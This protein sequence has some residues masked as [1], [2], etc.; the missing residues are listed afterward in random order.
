AIGATGT[1]QQRE[2]RQKRCQPTQSST[3]GCHLPVDIGWREVTGVTLA[4]RI[5]VGTEAIGKPVN[6]SPDTRRLPPPADGGH[7]C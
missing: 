5:I 4:D 7:S 6:P 3:H 1:S 2:C